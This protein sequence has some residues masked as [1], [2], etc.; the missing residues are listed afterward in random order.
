MGQYTIFA[1]FIKAGVNMSKDL[2]ITFKDMDNLSKTFRDARTAQ[3]LVNRSVFINSATFLASYFRLGTE[4]FH[5]LI[6]NDFDGDSKSLPDMF[7]LK[8]GLNLSG[9]AGKDRYVSS[10][11]SKLVVLGSYIFSYDPSLRI[12][13]L[14]EKGKISFINVTL[15]KK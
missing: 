12:A 15:E 4:V 8:N 14:S 2:S 1:L 11:T 6:E 10:L 3:N 9:K 7:N 13:D 5:N